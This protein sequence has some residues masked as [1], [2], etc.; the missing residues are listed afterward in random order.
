ML[1][2]Y[3]QGD[4]M[5]STRRSALSGLEGKDKVEENLDN[6]N[7]AVPVE[8]EKALG[9]SLGSG[10]PR[11]YGVMPKLSPEAAAAFAAYIDSSR[12]RAAIQGRSI[13]Y[14]IRWGP[15][16]LPSLRKA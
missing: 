4:I 7:L 14:T 8:T 9:A 13:F 6:K 1:I 11:G 10:T 15:D 2:R 16:T 3:N 12:T 5:V